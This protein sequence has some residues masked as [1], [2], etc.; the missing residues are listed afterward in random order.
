MI[1]FLF[2]IALGIITI[3]LY[4]KNRNNRKCDGNCGSCRNIN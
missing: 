2:V 4:R 1:G 3:L